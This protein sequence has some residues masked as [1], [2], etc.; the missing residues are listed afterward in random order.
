[1]N[2]IHIDGDFY[3][4]RDKYQWILREAYTVGKG[5]NAG[6]QAYRDVGYYARL[7]HVADKVA[8]LKV[9]AEAAEN[10]NALIRA[11]EKLSGAI[12][13]KLENAA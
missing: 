3:L 1:M 12:L 8:E 13:G 5:A 6:Q 11:V 9:K 10:V 7:S 2:L 4:D